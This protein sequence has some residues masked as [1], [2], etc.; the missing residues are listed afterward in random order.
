MV[1]PN[2]YPGQ[3]GE[4]EHAGSGGHCRDAGHPARV[5][6]PEGGRGRRAARR[7]RHRP[8]VAAAHCPAD[9]PS[10]PGLQQ[11]ELLSRDA[12]SKRFFLGRV[13]YDLGQVAL[14]RYDLREICTPAL[15]RIA[16]RTGDTVF[17]V[18]RHGHHGLVVDRQDGR[19]AVRTMP[20]EI[21]MRRPLGVGASGLALLMPMPDEQVRRFAL[22]YARQ[23]RGRAI[24]AEGLPRSVAKFRTRGYAVSRGYGHPQL[25]GIGMPL[26]ENA[27][28]AVSVTALS[29]RMTAAH[30][31]AV[32][33]ALREEMAL[34]GTVLRRV[35]EGRGG[36]ST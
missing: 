20:L 26:P 32:L 21:G 4:A 29:S 3:G 22:D 10:D 13:A 28:G 19:E 2:G 25:C 5:L 17:L 35:P 7:T 16:F 11:E 36:M 9:P 6:D 12:A 23:L 24:G 31:Q 33:E 18:A 8:A 15:R 30:R 34:L 1:T 14:P 27:P